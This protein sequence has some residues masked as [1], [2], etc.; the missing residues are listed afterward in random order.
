MLLQLI[1]PFA[2]MQVKKMVGPIIASKIIKML[3]WC[4]S[5]QVAFFLSS[6]KIY[7]EQIITILQYV[8]E[9]K[10]VDILIIW[11]IFDYI[12]IF[13]SQA[14]KLKLVVIIILT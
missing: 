4:Y 2:I 1:T 7:E 10:I 11:F 13:L 6:N 14:V 8:K 9:K 12:L 3:S 5:S